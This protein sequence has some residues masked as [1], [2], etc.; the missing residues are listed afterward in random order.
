MG[1]EIVSYEEEKD[2]G[3]DRH[4]RYTSPYTRLLAD[5]PQTPREIQDKEWDSLL[6]LSYCDIQDI[7]F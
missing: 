4:A 5:A 3:R 7:V 1:N 2:E 6:S